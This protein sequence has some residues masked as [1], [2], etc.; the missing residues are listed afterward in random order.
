MSRRRRGSAL[1]FPAMMTE[2]SCASYEVIARR[3]L[4]MVT[5][6]CSSAEYRRMAQEKT[7]AATST[8]RLV[9]NGRPASAA[10]LL[11]PWHSRAT[12]N[13]KRLRRT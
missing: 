6:T 1:A 7:A 13:A 2:L 9:T 12:A 4:M 5:G 11:A 8:L 10:A 3:M